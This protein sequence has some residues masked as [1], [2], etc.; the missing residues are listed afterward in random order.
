MRDC[1]SFGG[2]VEIKTAI[3]YA[4]VDNPQSIINRDDGIISIFDF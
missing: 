4:L 1:R 2:N 3:Y